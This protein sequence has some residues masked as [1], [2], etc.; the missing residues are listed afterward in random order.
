MLAIV[1]LLCTIGALAIYSCTKSDLA[2]AGRPATAKL[3]LQL[4]WIVIGL[5]MLVATALV[6]TAKLRRLVWPLYI[7]VMVLLVLVLVLPGSVRETNRWISLGPVNL[8]PSELAKL[9]VILMLGAV[10]ARVDEEKWDFTFL[11]KTL[12]YVGVPSLLILMQPDL[13]TPILLFFVWLTMMFVL[14]AN[15]AHLGAFAL[16]AIMLFAGAWGFGLIRPH[17]KARLVS[18]INPD[19]DP[20]GTAYHLRQS[21]IAIGSGHLWGQ[22]LFQGKQSQSAFVPDQETDFIFTVIAEELGF[23]GAASVL[24][25]Y[26]LLLYRGLAVSAAAATTFDRVVAAGI[27]AV[28]LIQIYSNIAMTVG[29]APVKGMAL[30]FL[31]Y[32]GSS[33][34]TN[35]MGI[36]IL[37]SIY[38]RREQIV[39]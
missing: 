10:V 17:Q 35:M 26:G 5:G 13:G 39:F 22:G 32:G 8:Q 33:M 37:Q 25:L 34:V 6:D 18:F 23:V 16:A 20:Y 11:V 15:P 12:G 4:A 30:P 14:G 31:S 29:L 36:G 2:A 3:Q 27:V 28:F 19:A 9:A 7:G 1:L 21:L 38:M 24:V